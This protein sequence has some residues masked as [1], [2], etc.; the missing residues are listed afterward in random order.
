VNILEAMSDPLLFGNWFRTRESWSAWRVFLASLF[1]L[2]IEDE[3][4]YASCTGNRPLPPRQAREAYL[5]AGRRAGKSFVAALVAVFLAA[6]RIY[7]LSPGERGVVMLLAAD[8]RQSRVLFRYARAFL[9]N[10][11]MLKA[12]A[13][14]LRALSGSP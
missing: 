8:R 7:K 1:A 13:H 2:P 3:K 5:I 6:F 11:P 10:V 12:S 4:I 9:E 14:L